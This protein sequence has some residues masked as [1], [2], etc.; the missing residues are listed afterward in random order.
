MLD[1]TLKAYPLPPPLYRFLTVFVVQIRCDFKLALCPQLFSNFD[2]LG[3]LLGRARAVSS[4]R[5]AVR[6]GAADHEGV[7]LA[8]GELLVPGP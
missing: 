1:S 3:V 8:G 7:W 4:V 2:S 5:P 6:G